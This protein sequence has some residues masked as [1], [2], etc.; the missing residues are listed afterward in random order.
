M[1]CSCGHH[2]PRHDAGHDD[3][4]TGG[5]PVAL[6]VPMVAV[7]GRLICTDAAQMMTALSL[8]PDHA[9][10]SRAEPGC[11]RFDIWQDDDPLVWHLR[12][13]FTDEAAFAAHQARTADSAWGRDSTGIGRDLQRH[14]VMPAIRPETAADHDALDRLLHTAF[15]GP[16]EAQLVRT[17]RR[18]GDL[19]LSLVAHAAGTA[20]GHV[21]LSPL[22]G[23]HPALALAP[24]A[25]APKARGLGIGA[26][27]VRDAI[28]RAG[29]TP[30]VVLGDP[31]YYRRFGF[32][33]VDLD[34]PHAGPALMAIGD[35]PAGST[36]RHAPAFAAL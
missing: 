20:L 14:A 18:Q 13:L 33:P 35:L 2:H 21:A 36:I 27:L 12:E 4:G 3:C 23:S 22:S 17:L 10:L 32:A 26:A 25:V 9:E 11:L 8:M 19:S 7:H 34:S 30:I 24:L 1:S 28:A 5:T 16:Q 31:A 29:A 6:P 15:G